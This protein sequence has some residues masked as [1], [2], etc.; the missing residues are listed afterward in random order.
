MCTMDLLFPGIKL[1]ASLCE[2]WQPRKMLT[3]TE[4]RNCQ[5]VLLNHQ[6]TVDLSACLMLPS[7]ITQIGFK[8]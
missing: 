6:S 5:C 3:H 8:Y 2:D 1:N 4:H 7:R